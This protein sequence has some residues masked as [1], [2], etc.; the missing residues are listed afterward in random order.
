MN[1]QTDA[2]GAL[3]LWEGAP[4]AR[5]QSQPGCEDRLTALDD[6]HILWQR[7]ADQPTD[8]MT[9]RLRAERPMTHA[10][11]PGVTYTGNDWGAKL[12]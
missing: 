12:D 6:C 1:I 10:M 5:A 8:H 7:H 4:V 9:L 3:L 2:Q 11:G